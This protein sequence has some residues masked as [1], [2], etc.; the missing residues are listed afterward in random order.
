MT[1]SK[2]TKRALI[3]SALS[4]VICLT[5]LI[6]STFA[7]FTDTETVATS[8][9]VAGTLDIVIL[10]E[11]GNEK[12]TALAFED[13]NGNSDI[14]W[15]P[16]ATFRTEG[17]QLKNVGNLW[18]KY[19]LEINNTEISYNKLNE[20]ID[21]SLVKADG[22]KIDLATMK[23]IALAPKTGVSEIMYIEGTM[24][25]DAG[26]AYQGLTLSGVSI[27]V[28]ATQYASEKDMNDATYDENAEYPVKVITVN[29]ADEFVKAFAEIKNGESI[30]LGA[31][32]DM[33][34]K[35]WTPVNNKGFVFDGNNKTVTGLGNALV[36]TTAALEYTI[37]DVTFKNLTVNG[38][39]GNASAG[40]IGYADT[41]AYI[42]MENV[43]IDGAVI[44][45]AEYIGGFV[46]YTSGYGVDSNG[47]VNASHNFTNCTIKNAQLNSASDGAIGGLIGHA[48]SNAATTTRIKNFAYES[49]T[50]TQT[51]TRTD[52]I[53]NMIGTANIGVVY[54][55]DADIVIADDIGRFVP[56]TTGKL[57]V[58][59]EEIA[60]FDGK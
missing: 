41:C 5:M 8:N 43:T 33:T 36:G 54:V 4:I 1:N 51:E 39:F 20:V 17:F 29:N 50:F 56:G 16:N 28:Y 55:E 6:G 22:T 32:I 44:G 52:K 49:L 14:L 18:L 9:I 13:V 35:A 11:E 48:G 59:N 10:D 31:D 19:K 40:L 7:W 15:E 42:N 21:F 23:D 34:G 12:T 30:V 57:V 45:G 26:N 58:N 3:A 24:D 2:S 47:P 53:G 27:T 46:G 60:A 37:K 25:K 38:N